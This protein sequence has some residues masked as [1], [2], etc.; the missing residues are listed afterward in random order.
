MIGKD[1]DRRLYYCLLLNN[2]DNTELTT[3]NDEEL[4]TM[5]DNR[6]IVTAAKL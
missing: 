6:K 2:L 3:L 5:S 4:L 1:E